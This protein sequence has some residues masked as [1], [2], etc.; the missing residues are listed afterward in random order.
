MGM[1]MGVGEDAAQETCPRDMMCCPRDKMHFVL[2]KR[3]AQ[4][5]CPR[6]VM[7]KM[8]KRDM[9]HKMDKHGAKE[10]GTEGSKSINSLVLNNSLEEKVLVEQA[11]SSRSSSVL[12]QQCA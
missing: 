8:D 2:P 10:I 1:G 4:E 11:R 3:H 12:C 7:H 5:T 6:D 9:M